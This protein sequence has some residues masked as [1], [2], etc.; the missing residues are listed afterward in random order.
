VLILYRLEF[1]PNIK[2]YGE[3]LTDSEFG[4]SFLSL[5][6]ED[7]KHV[8]KDI[9]QT[10]YLASVFKFIKKEIFTFRVK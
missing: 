3:L 10:I 9:Y 5:W 8:L 7:I 6:T 4:V 2:M 1:N